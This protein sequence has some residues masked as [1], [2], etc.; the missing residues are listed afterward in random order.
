MEG[1][2]PAVIHL[3]TTAVFQVHVEQ[4]ID[5]LEA[6]L[7]LSRFD[8]LPMRILPLQILQLFVELGI[9]PCEL[10]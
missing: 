9:L 5:D 10:L 8:V 4:A 7:S 3:A 1:V 6:L 2:Y